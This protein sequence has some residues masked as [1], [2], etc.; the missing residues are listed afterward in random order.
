MKRF[1]SS[2]MMMEMCMP[3]CM[4]MFSCAHNS[5]LRSLITAGSHL[6][7]RCFIFAKEDNPMKKLYRLYTTGW[8]MCPPGTDR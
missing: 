6:A 7:S 4:C 2:S 5:H 1:V 3:M 8:R